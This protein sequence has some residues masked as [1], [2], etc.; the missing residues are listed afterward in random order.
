LASANSVLFHSRSWP[1][2]WFNIW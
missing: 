2:C 1:N